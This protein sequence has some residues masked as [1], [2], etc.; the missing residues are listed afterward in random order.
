[1]CPLHPEP[2]NASR[3]DLGPQR[4]EEQ[5]GGQP[6]TP[7]EPS[8]AQETQERGAVRRGNFCAGGKVSPT[9]PLSQGHGRRLQSRGGGGGGCVTPTPSPR[10]R[11]LPPDG[12]KLRKPPEDAPR[13]VSSPG[14]HAPSSPLASNLFSGRPRPRSPS[15]RPHSPPCQPFALH[16]GRRAQG[17]ILSAE[18]DKGAGREK[19]NGR[20]GF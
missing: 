14:R 16:P 11:R 13:G 15:A 20:E 12:P 19:G 9:K 10:R 1:M 18:E 17:L 7:A 3:P 8:P 6:E 4:C 2:P 5:G